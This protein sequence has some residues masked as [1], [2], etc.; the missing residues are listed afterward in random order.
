MPN[1]FK[2]INLMKIII[3]L[4]ILTIFIQSCTERKNENDIIIFESTFSEENVITLNKLVEQFDSYII[5]KYQINNSL[6]S[7]YKSFLVNVCHPENILSQKSD[8]IF[9]EKL[10]NQYFNSELNSEIILR[11]DSLVLI[12]G[13]KSLVRMYYYTDKEE[14]RI[15][16]IKDTLLLPPNPNDINIEQ[17]DLFKLLGMHNNLKIFN[18]F[19]QFYTGLNNI[20]NKNN[21]IKSY[22]D[23]KKQFLEYNDYHRHSGFEGFS[24][25]ACGLLENKTNLTDYFTKRIIIIELLNK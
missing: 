9:F 6:D 18:V 25:F 15:E 11:P 20:K 1:M 13:N 12:N 17:L 22:L 14:Q 4:L 21:F 23:N 24:S 3:P 10:R 2:N 7:A 16:V 8:S 5:N 19:G